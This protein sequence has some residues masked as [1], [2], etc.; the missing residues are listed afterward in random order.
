MTTPNCEELVFTGKNNINTITVSQ[1]VD[2]VTSVV[3]F[4]AT[5]RMRVIFKNS[6][7]EADSDESTDSIDWSA[8]D[9]KITF[10]FEELSVAAGRYPATLIQYDAD[11]PDGQVIFHMDTGGLRFRFIDSGL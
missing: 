9:G 11:H 7:Y 10:R 5:T 4:S 1:T 6:S 3:D 2:G 8:G